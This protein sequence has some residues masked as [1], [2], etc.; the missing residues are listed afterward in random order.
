MHANKAD[1]TL[2]L[3][4]L[5]VPFGNKVPID[6]IEPR[7]DVFGTAILIFQVVGVFPNIQYPDGGLNPVAQRR[8]L[9]RD[10]IEIG[11]TH[12]GIQITR[13][14]P[15]AAEKLLSRPQ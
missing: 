2:S 13:P 1:D 14:S 3:H 4:L 9:V 5:G 7:G 6:D 15:A 12:F 11:R 8:I 10:W